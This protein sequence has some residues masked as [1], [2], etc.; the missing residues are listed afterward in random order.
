VKKFLI[1]AIVLIP[2]ISFAE[3]LEHRMLGVWG[4]GEYS[5]ISYSDDNAPGDMEYKSNAGAGLSARY[6]FSDGMA[7]AEFGFFTSSRVNSKNEFM[8]NGG[9][10]VRDPYYVFAGGNY[11]MWSM[12]DN[13]ESKPGL[14]FQ[15]GIGTVITKNDSDCIFIEL[16]YK[17][18]K[19]KL[20]E[21]DYSF[22]G[23][24]P[25]FRI[26]LFSNIF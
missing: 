24:S 6:P 7:F 3:G 17:Y 11:T 5:N 23:T 9:Y 8:L 21:G 22:S 4:T 1:L 26:G 19:G 12:R 25:F 20:E 10:F 13:M 15:A 16:G 18:N 14:G 2:A